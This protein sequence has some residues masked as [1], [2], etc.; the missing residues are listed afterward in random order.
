[1]SEKKSKKIF[2]PVACPFSNKHGVAFEYLRLKKLIELQSRQKNVIFVC[3]CFGIVM[4]RDREVRKVDY[5]NII[6]KLT[7][8]YV[9][10][11]K[12]ILVTIPTN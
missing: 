2:Y 11:V 9:I 12:K 7:I 10:L 1:M 5:H 4:K 6:I 8:Y 3:K